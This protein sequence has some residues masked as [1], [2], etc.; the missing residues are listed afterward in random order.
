M[1]TTALIAAATLCFAGAA[2]LSV[3]AWRNIRRTPTTRAAG[4]DACGAKLRQ[5]SWPVLD[6]Q[7]LLDRSGMQ[8]TLAQIRERSG[9]AAANS[10]RTC[11]R[12]SWP[13]P[14]S[15]TTSCSESS[16]SRPARRAAG[17]CHRGGRRGAAPAGGAR[18]ASGRA[19]RA[20]RP[21]S[22]SLDVRRVPGGLASRHR[23]ADVRPAYPI[24][25]NPSMACLRRGSPWPA[26]SRRT[27]PCLHGRVSKHQRT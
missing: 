21:F 9:L 3:Y 20:G 13:S 12:F 2:G 16:S 6:G 4:A 26:R 10:S 22:A 1:S 19:D 27:A 8:G 7:T 23:P 18:A 5:G 14:R 25:S 11:S 17:S 15:S 24:L